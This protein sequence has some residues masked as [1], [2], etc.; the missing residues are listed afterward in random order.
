MKVLIVDDDRELTELLCFALRRAGHEALP[1]YD[2][3][4]ARRLLLEGSPDLAVLDINLGTSDGLDLLREIRRQSEMPVIMLTGRDSEQDKVMGL[5]L[6]ADDY[7]T[8]PFGI[9]ELIAR[10][11][12]QM[13]RRR[14]D[15]WAPQASGDAVLQAGPLTLNSTE[16][17]ASKDG[18]PLNLTP[19]EFRLLR[20]LMQHAGAVVPLPV[21][22]KQVWGYDAGSPTDVVRVTTHRLRSK[23]EED[24]GSSELLQTVPGVGIMLRV[25]GDGLAQFQESL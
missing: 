6:G 1:S 3:P 25:P 8:K 10:I 16:H 23:L 19:T 9:R 15:E 2:A 22:L 5:T 14:V 13:R 20:C 12:A 18:R 4:T 7:V 17:R 21:L 24:S 11:H